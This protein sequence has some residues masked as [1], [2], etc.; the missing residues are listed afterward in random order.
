MWDCPFWVDR[1][2][3]EAKG[4]SAHV[5][6]VVWHFNFHLWRLQKDASK[7]LSVAMVLFVGV[8]SLATNWGIIGDVYER[9]VHV[10]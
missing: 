1:R 2:R 4:S 7:P 8:V 3:A 6:F 9:T 10:C 5:S